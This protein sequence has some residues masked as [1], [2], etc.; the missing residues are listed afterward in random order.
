MGRFQGLGRQW[1]ANTPEQP[2]DIRNHEHADSHIASCSG[3]RAPG[4]YLQTSVIN[5]VFQELNEVPTQTLAR[6]P[7]SIE[8]S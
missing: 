2:H 7:A 6:W 5:N 4:V 3:K 1:V 8:S